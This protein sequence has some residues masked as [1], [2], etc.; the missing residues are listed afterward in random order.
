MSKYAVL[1]V[2]ILFLIFLGLYWF[3]AVSGYWTT[4]IAIIFIIVGF[5]VGFLL[6]GSGSENMWIGVPLFV[7]GI[8]LLFIIW[9]FPR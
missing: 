9:F 4:M 1:G 5:V 3:G 8:I 6:L 2:V 7:F